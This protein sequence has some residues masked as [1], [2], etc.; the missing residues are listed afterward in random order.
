[1]IRQAYHGMR[2]SVSRIARTRWRDAALLMAELRSETS[3]GQSALDGLIARAMTAGAPE[4]AEATARL[5]RLLRRF[6]ASDAILESLADRGLATGSAWT[7]LERAARRRGPQAVASL[8]ARL[9]AQLL[10]HH[11]GLGDHIICSGLV[12]HLAAA[13]PRVGLFAKKG[14][15]TS[16]RFLY[17]DLPSIEV[18]PVEDDEEVRIFLRR[19]DLPVW[20]IGFEHVV[21]STDGFAEGFYRQYGQD[22]ALRWSGFRLQRDRAQEAQLFERLDCAR[23]PYV[24]LHDDPSRGL[25]IRRDLLPQGMRVIFPDR[26]LDETLFDWSMVLEKAAEIHCMDSS[27]RHLVDCLQ[28]ETDKLFLHHYVKRSDV[29]SRHAW[30]RIYR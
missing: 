2:K 22:Y 26:A 4:L 16:V 10:Y 21:S 13:S 12:R 8:H 18:I 25:L 19:F 17:R 29:P 24:F 1:M 30:R 11:L 5:C 27:F 3:D 14:Y 23:E 28:P 15:A 7:A 9:P 6:E 20:R